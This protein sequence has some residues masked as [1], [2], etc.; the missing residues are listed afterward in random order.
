MMVFLVLYF[1]EKPRRSCGVMSEMPRTVHFSPCDWLKL[2]SSQIIALIL[3][4]YLL[5]IKGS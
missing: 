4:N 5:K 3:S 1:V 2:S